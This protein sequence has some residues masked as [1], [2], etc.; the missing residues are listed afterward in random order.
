MTEKASTEKVVRLDR[1]RVRSGGDDAGF[2][3]CPACQD[4]RGDFGVV[5][6]GLPA[7]PYVAAVICAACDLEIPVQDGAV[8]APP[9][10]RQ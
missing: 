3:G 6:R 9:Q 7:R 1:Y 2:L 5:C 4:E 8:R 10:V